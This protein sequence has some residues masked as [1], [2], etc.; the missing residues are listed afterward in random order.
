[1]ATYAIKAD[2]FFLPGSSVEGGY[3]TVSD[4]VFGTWSAEA[5]EGV[6]VPPDA[7]AGRAR[8]ARA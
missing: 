1:M 6:E 3:L 4:G 8:R 2:R 7:G 5:P